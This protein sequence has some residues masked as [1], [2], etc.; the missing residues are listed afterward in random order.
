MGLFDFLTGKKDK[1]GLGYAP[2]MGGNIPFY[3]PLVKAFMPVT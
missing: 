2:T 1:K 3:A